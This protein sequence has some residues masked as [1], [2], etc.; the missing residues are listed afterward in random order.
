MYKCIISLIRNAPKLKFVMLL[1]TKEGYLWLI[2]GY[3]N[4][5]MW[6]NVIPK[7]LA[8]I[9]CHYSLRSSG[10]LS[11]KNLGSWLQG[12]TPVP[13]PIHPKRVGCGWGQGSSSSTPKRENHLIYG[14]GFKTRGHCPDETRQGPPQTDLPSLGIKGLAWTN[15]KTASHQRHGCPHTCGGHIEYLHHVN[16]GYVVKAAHWHI[17]SS[18]FISPCCILRIHLQSTYTANLCF[19][20]TSVH[21]LSKKLKQMGEGTVKPMRTK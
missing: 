9:C 17:N 2:L 1:R 19:S 14:P 15:K 5:H 11:Q 3:N 13:V 6:P 12:F 16:T 20:K 4:K 10:R 18:S 21:K 7:P 8:L